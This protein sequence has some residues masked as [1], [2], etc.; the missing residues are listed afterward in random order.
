[1][2]T[3]IPYT[4]GAVLRK[5]KPK[6]G[7]EP[8]EIISRTDKI[9][10]SDEFREVLTEIFDLV[11]LDENGTLS[12]E[13]FNLFNWRTSGEQIAD[14][15]WEVVEENFPL[16]NGELTLEGFNTLHL[17]EAEENS[18][19]STELWVTLQSMG[20]DRNLAQSGSAGY[21]LTV[22]SSSVDPPA[23]EISGLKSGGLIL[24]K[25]MIR[26]VMEGSESP[27]QIPG[28]KHIW[29]YIQRSDDIASIV[30]QNKTERNQTIQVDLTGSN[31]II[32]S[33]QSMKFS[34]TVGKK[35]SILA[36]HILPNQTD[37]PWNYTIST[38]EQ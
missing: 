28:T 4:T 34:I 36:V 11:D 21:R 3:I 18:G 1:M 25:T 26:S 24:E 27:I 31:N 16:K 9:G 37:L 6:D 7:S 5:A 38:K 8:K 23:L 10:L 19:D 33:R 17:M 30:V 12:R 35:S 15:E 32:T 13:E 14:E 29:V 22:S 2:Y 20:Y